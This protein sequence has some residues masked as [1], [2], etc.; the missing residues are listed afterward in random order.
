VS[1]IEK[2]TILMI[3]DISGY[4]K[5]MV[6]NKM[7]QTHAQVVITELIKTIIKQVKI[8]L[9]ISKLEGDAV[10]FFAEKSDVMERWE[11][12]RREI[13]EK[14]IEFFEVFSDKINELAESNTCK[15]DACM[16]IEKLNLKVIVHS[17]TALFYKIDKFSELSGVDVIIVHK[18]LKNSVRS[19]RYILV[20]KSALDTIQFPQNIFF[21]KS[22]E[23]YKDI[24][25]I[26][27]YI[28]F[29]GGDEGFDH[30]YS[31][32]SYKI[33]NA[34]IKMVVPMMLNLGIKKLKKFNNLP[35]ISVS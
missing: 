25:K 24:G 14:L 2:E 31:A 33:K 6:T 35:E 17:G 12:T 26:G 7:A 3:A 9:E 34:V 4:T 30:G 32:L 11:E 28:Y 27:T 22:K 23:D 18:L 8:P 10:F 21:E 29:P 15:C 19:D 16:H 5:F 20:T 13:G 1:K